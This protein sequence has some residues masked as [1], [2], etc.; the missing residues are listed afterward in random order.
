[1]AIIKKGH[2]SGTVGPVVFYHAYGVDIVRSRPECVK[3][4]SLKQ[5]A[6]QMKMKLTMC[7]LYGIRDIVK[8]SFQSNKPYV[9]GHIMARSAILKTSFIG[10]YPNL[11]L[12]Y[13]EI[14]L[15]GSSE[16]IIQSIT[17]SYNGETLDLKLQ[18]KPR[19]K[20]NKYS[21]LIVQQADEE[22]QST[23]KHGPFSPCI[24][25]HYHLTLCHRSYH[26]ENQSFWVMLYDPL[27]A[28]IYGSCYLELSIHDTVPRTFSYND[29]L[30]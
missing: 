6:Q 2:V 19:W 25:D 4:R 9:N 10:T 21:L 17:A 16:R 3:P 15:S 22:D 23:Y 13:P 5:L 14:V 12:N 24:N 18:F 27:H 28:Y 1:M 8:I 29:D 30:D 7:F 26:R 11:S 20:E